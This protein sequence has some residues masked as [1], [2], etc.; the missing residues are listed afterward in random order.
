MEDYASSD[1]DYHYDSDQDDSVEAYENDE[2]YA[3]LSSKGPTTKVF[4]S[5]RIYRFWDN[6]NFFLLSKT[7]NYCDFLSSRYMTAFVCLCVGYLC[8]Y[9][10]FFLSCIGV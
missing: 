7:L 10:F 3:L 9:F 4:P 2:D 8:M 6:P 1:E 5:D